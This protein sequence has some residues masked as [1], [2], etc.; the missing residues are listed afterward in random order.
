MTKRDSFTTN[1][2]P[3]KKRDERRADLAHDLPDHMIA[4]AGKPTRISGV[5]LVE[6]SNRR[7]EV[8]T[9]RC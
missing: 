8:V 3:L 4:G 5:R 2:A 7:N 9:E 1:R 6:V